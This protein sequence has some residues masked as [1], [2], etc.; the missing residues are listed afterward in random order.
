MRLTLGILVYSGL[1]IEVS[2]IYKWRVDDV[3]SVIRSTTQELQTIHRLVIRDS[4]AN[5]L[6][7]QM[8]IWEEGQT[9][10]ILILIPKWLLKWTWNS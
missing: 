6:T 3:R 8:T 7:D 9:E 1:K 5:H 2:K 4:F 10:T